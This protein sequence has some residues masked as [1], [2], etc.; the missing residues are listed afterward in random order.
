MG[1][2]LKNSIIILL[3]FSQFS[4]IYS[5]SEREQARTAAENGYK[6]FLSECFIHSHRGNFNLSSQ[7]TVEN[8]SLGEPI[9]LMDLTVDKIV[10]YQHG[11]G[12]SKLLIKRHSFLFPVYFD[13][14]MKL[15]LTVH[16][17]VSLGY[18]HYEIAALGSQWLAEE[19]KKI[20]RTMPLPFN[21]AM[22]VADCYEANAYVYTFPDLNDQNLGFIDIS[23]ENRNDYSKYLQVDECVE[24]MKN[25]IHPDIKKG[26]RK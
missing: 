1:G 13:G 8:A 26:V 20:Q 9:E 2:T 11:D 19:I 24:I 23:G 12:V 25:S 15:I 10:S 3:L 21:A 16:K 14:E 4:I 17:Y 6:K 7:E 18:D 5:D 22:I